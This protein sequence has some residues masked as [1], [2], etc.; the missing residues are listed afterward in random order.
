MESEGLLPHSQAPATLTYPQPEYSRPFLS[1]S[2]F[3]DPFYIIF[4]YMPSGVF[5]SGLPTKT[6]YTPLL[7]PI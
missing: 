5:L 4:P 7:S 1:I 6:L 2:L 3:E